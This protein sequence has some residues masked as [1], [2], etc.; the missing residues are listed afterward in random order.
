LI[1][2]KLQEYLAKTRKEILSPSTSITSLK[3]PEKT[4]D[5]EKED[6]MNP[7]QEDRGSGF[8]RLF[9]SLKGKMNQYLSNAIE[10]FKIGKHSSSPCTMPSSC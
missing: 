8:G 5:M 7:Q 2:Q 9:A 4:L 6:M 1:D 3:N 10:W